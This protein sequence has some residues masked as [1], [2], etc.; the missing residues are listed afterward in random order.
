MNN[1]QKELEEVYIQIGLNVLDSAIGYDHNGSG[2]PVSTRKAF[3]PNISERDM[4]DI[5][6]GI[7][8]L[9]QQE[10]EV[11]KETKDKIYLKHNSPPI[12]K[13][14]IKGSGL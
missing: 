1:V 12:K 4:S 10:L 13:A 2:R 7:Y 11:Q 6:I 9:V 3:A 8:T 5:V 14:L